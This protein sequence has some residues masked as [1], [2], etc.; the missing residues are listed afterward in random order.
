MNYNGT[1]LTDLTEKEGMEQPKI[2]W[3]PSIAVCGIDFY[4]GDAFPDWKNDLFVTGLASQ[5]L[6]RVRIV[7]NEVV[8]EEV[9]LK[10]HG[11]LRDVVSGPDGSLYVAANLGR[12]RDPGSAI[13]R[14]SPVER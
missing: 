13:L 12:S 11:R 7:G 14:L 9:I 10:G 4:R 3:T 8:E 6:H 5:Q 2:D 1:P